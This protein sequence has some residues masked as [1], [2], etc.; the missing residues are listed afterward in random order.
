MGKKKSAGAEAKATWVDPDVAPELTKEFFED[1]EVFAGDTFVRRGRGRPPTGNAKELISVRL[2]QEV[3]SLLR[4]AGPGW[5]TQINTLLRQGLGLEVEA[6]VPESPLQ[7]LAK[8]AAHMLVMS[9]A[10]YCGPIKE[11]EAEPRIRLTRTSRASSGVRFGVHPSY[12]PK[13]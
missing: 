13:D 12:P 8:E 2:D 11:S 4:Q 10:P 9:A 3:L 6:G 1:A 7:G 5:Q